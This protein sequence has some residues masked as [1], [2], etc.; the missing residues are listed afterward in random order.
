MDRIRCVFE[1][2]WQASELCQ[3]DLKNKEQQY[4][5]NLQPSAHAF[6]HQFITSNGF[7]EAQN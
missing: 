4:D 2:W 5:S 1:Q 7:P 6:D 3:Q